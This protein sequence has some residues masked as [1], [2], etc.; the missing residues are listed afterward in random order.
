MSVRAAAAAA[1]LNGLSRFALMFLFVFYFQGPQ[2]DDPITAG[3][4]LIPLAAGMLV[5][6]P[7]AGWWADRHGSRTLAAS[8]M[9]VTALGLALMTTLQADTAYWQGMIWLAL[10]GVGSGMFLSPNTAAMIK[11]PPHITSE[12]IFKSSE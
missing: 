4:K 10:V 12:P 8:G 9:L 3:I 6:S 7:I 11:K 1:F 5:A 2:Q